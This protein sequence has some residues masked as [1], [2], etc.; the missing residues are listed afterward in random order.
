MTVTD[1]SLKNNERYAKGFGKGSSRCRP[2]RTWPSSPAW[3]LGWT[4]LVHWG[5]KRVTRT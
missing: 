5:S 4:R 1:D 3:T 2:Q